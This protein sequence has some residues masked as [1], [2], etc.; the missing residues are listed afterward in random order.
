V[1]A[2]QEQGPEFKFL[3][4]KK[5]ERKKENAFMRCHKRGNAQRK[6]GTMSIQIKARGRSA[7][8]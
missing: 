1:P 8:Q 3:H 5:K 4:H 6:Q 2:W 7:H